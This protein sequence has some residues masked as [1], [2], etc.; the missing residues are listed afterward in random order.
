MNHTQDGAATGLEGTLVER[1]SD[2]EFAASR[3]YCAPFS[4]VY[5]AWSDPKA[6]EHWWVPQS[7]PGM[8]LLS[9][10]MDVRTGGKYRLE[11]SM[12]EADTM[13]F[14][15]RYL[16]VV[17]N[18]HIIWTNDEGDEGAITTVTFEDFG[19]QTKVTLRELYPTTEGLE[20]ALASSALALPE[21]FAQL[22]GW[23]GLKP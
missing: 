14:Y 5:A 4:A 9:C 2:F 11:F 23:L 13:A 3:S 8:H 15:G 10:E 1:L 6:F 12:G 20:E 19:V 22:A 21:Q 16:H 7:A 17:E 18:Q